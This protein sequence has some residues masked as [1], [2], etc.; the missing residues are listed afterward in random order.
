M[1]KRTIRLVRSQFNSD[2]RDNN[3]ITKII[4][5]IVKKYQYKEDKLLFKSELEYLVEQTKKQQ[6]LDIIKDLEYLKSNLKNNRFVEVHNRALDVAIG[7]I[8][9][10]Q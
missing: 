2:Y 10:K 1:V 5:S 8:K 7:L 6:I 9:E 3:M 4:N